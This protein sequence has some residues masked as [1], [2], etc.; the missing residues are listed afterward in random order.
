AVGAPSESLRS[1]LVL[2]G[3][4]GTGSQFPE[5]AEQRGCRFLIGEVSER[6][7]GGE[8]GRGRVEADADEIL[9]APGGQRIDHRTEFDGPVFPSGEYDGA[10]AVDDPGAR[11]GRSLGSRAFRSGVARPAMPEDVEMEA[12]RKSHVGLEGER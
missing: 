4:G 3:R 7:R 10:G 8:V 6:H 1:R 2:L 12:R 11:T 5:E 9:V